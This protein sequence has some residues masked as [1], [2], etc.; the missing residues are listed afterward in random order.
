MSSAQQVFR[1]LVEAAGRRPYVRQG[2]IAPFQRIASDPRTTAVCELVG[3]EPETFCRFCQIVC[4]ALQ[5]AHNDWYQQV[6]EEE[7]QEPQRIAAARAAIALLKSDSIVREIVLDEEGALEIL[8]KLD[9]SLA[10]SAEICRILLEKLPYRRRNKPRQYSFVTFTARGISQLFGQPHYELVAA[11]ASIFFAEDNSDG[12]LSADAVK[13]M[14]QRE[15]KEDEAEWEVEQLIDSALE[16][17]RELEGTNS[18]A[19]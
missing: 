17:H 18:G 7:R 3:R 2:E 11:L 19:R 4:A 1:T 8:D 9:R 12:G 5:S 14:V 6:R 13:K 15:R 10:E 16:K